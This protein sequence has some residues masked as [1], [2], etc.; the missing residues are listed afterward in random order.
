[1]LDISIPKIVVN[2]TSHSP[3]IVSSTC[4]LIMCVTTH[5]SLHRGDGYCMPDVTT[6]RDTINSSTGMGSHHYPLFTIASLYHSFLLIFFLFAE[7][8]SLLNVQEPQLA[9]FHAQD[10]LKLAASMTWVEGQNHVFFALVKYLPICVL[11]HT[12]DFGAWSFIFA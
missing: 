3:S 11:S 7:L 4:R 9:F 12:V 2:A 10:F 6:M 5:I 8:D 1:M